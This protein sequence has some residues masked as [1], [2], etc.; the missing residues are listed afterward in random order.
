MPSAGRDRADAAH[1]L[2]G[3]TPL[4]TRDQQADRRR[5][6]AALARR[7]AEGDVLERANAHRVREGDDREM[8][9][10]RCAR[11]RP[12]RSEAAA[13]VCSGLAHRHTGRD[14]RDGGGLSGSGPGHDLRTSTSIF[15]RTS[16]RRSGSQAIE[17]RPGNRALVHHILV[18]YEAPPDGP[19][20]APRFSRIAKTARSPKRERALGNRPPR[21]TGMPHRLLATY[22]PGT[23]AQVFPAGTALRLAPGGTSP[24]AGA[25]HRQR[26][27][28][29][30]SQQGG[31]DLRE[32]A[33]GR[34]DPPGAVH[35][36]AVHDP[37][38]APWTI[39]SRRT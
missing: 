21:D 16:A 34:G 24:L 31:S 33:A 7:R 17:A 25:L 13:D 3:S 37:R 22:A 29:H 20:V 4:G 10:W 39:R 14:L 28:R 1:Q 27:G 36:R 2:S 6:D 11:R 38:R 8:G 12:Q 32:G 19:R 26:H 18:Y 9:C 30:R 5:R 35:Q 23:D 15:R